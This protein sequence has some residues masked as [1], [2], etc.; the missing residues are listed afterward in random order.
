MSAFLLCDFRLTYAKTWTAVF[1]L[2]GGSQE[3]ERAVPFL[4]YMRVYDEG[5]SLSCPQR[6]LY[7]CAFA[8]SL[9]PVLTYLVVRDSCLE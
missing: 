9:S 6:P 1:L 2:R 8:N 7:Y 4:K 5:G 3:K